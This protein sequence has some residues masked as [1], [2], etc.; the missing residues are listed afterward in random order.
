MAGEVPAFTWSVCLIEERLRR[1]DLRFRRFDAGF[2]GDG[3]QVGVT[4]GEHHEIARVFERIFGGLQVLGGGAGSV[5]GLPI[6]QRLSHRHSCIKIGKGANG[7]GNA[8]S[9]K[10][11]KPELS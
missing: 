10:A 1:L 5:D 9:G 8:D 6:K 3:L 7:R 4:Y 11:G 2:V